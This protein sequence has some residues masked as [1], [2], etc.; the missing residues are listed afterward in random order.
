MMLSFSGC[1]LY[2][3]YI[4]CI[5]KRKPQNEFRYKKHI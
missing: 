5:L 4:P 1:H 3:L 2:F